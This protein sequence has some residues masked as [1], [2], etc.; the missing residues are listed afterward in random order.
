MDLFQLSTL[1]VFFSLRMLYLLVNFI[2]FI[3]L[4]TAFKKL[5]LVIH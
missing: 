2:D 5:H 1:C 4:V 3:M